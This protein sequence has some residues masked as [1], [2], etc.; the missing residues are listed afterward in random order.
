MNQ[1]VGAYPETWRDR[2]V[3]ARALAHLKRWEE[4]EVDMVKVARIAP[5]ERQ[6]LIE[7]GSIYIENGHLDEA[8]SDF[9]RAIELSPDGQAECVSSQWWV[10]GPCDEDDAPP[11]IW[12][13]ASQQT[14][15]P[16]ATHSNT[17]A[18]NGTAKSSEDAS[19]V[20]GEGFWP[21]RKLLELDK[22]LSVRTYSANVNHVM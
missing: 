18:K 9:Q 5:D 17:E 4:A 21:N 14:D 20:E 16:D 3:R 11:E 2:L 12:A 1:V 15:A 7:R 6:A 22:L 19:R 13:V 8:E 10:A